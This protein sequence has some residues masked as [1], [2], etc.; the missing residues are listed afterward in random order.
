MSQQ[1]FDWYSFTHIIHGFIFFAL[2]HFTMPRM[3]VAVRFLVAGG[4]EV[5]WEILENPPAVIQHYRRQAL[6][7]GQSDCA[8]D[9][10]P[11]LAIHDWRACAR[12]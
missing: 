6:A 1:M 12:R 4:I 2:L 3:P 8:S 10:A 7:A 5:G 9:W 11:I